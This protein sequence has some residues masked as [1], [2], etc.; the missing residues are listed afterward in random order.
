M[1]STIRQVLCVPAE[2]KKNAFREPIKVQVLNP[3]D[4]IEDNIPEGTIHFLKIDAEEKIFILLITRKD[5]LN[6]IKYIAVGVHD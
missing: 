2:D 6:R 3:N 5:V 1:P 4:I